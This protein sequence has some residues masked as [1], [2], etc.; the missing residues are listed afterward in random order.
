MFQFCKRI[1]D[2]MRDF[3]SPRIGVVYVIHANIIFWILYTLILRPVL[4]L[5]TGSDKIIVVE[6][7]KELLEYF[8]EEDLLLLSYQEEDSTSSNGD[9]ESTKSR[10]SFNTE[11]E[12]EGE[13][14]E[15]GDETIVTQ[16]ITATSP[17]AYSNNIGAMVTTPNA[18]S[19]LT[20]ASSGV[21]FNEVV[22]EEVRGGNGN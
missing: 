17:I 3:Y 8:H 11:G 20:K 2:D 14:N 1:V 22:D 4:G 10:H 18:R 19:N 12:N 5:W 6:S 9:T 7:P 15:V 13:V 16:S 21:R